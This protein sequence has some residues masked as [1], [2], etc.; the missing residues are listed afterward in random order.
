MGMS[1]HPGVHGLTSTDHGLLTQTDSS[2]TTSIGTPTA[3]VKLSL[4]DGAEPSNVAPR[5]YKAARTN[6]P[7]SMAQ[8]TTFSQPYIPS[9]S[10]LLPARSQNISTGLDSA[11]LLYEY[12]PVGLDDWMPPVDAVYRPHVVHHVTAGAGSANAKPGMSGRSKR[13]FSDDQ[14]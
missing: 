3:P 5:S 14:S 11:D 1:A 7:G 6:Y 13:Y 10:A 9:S 8:P 4:A 2:P 12:F